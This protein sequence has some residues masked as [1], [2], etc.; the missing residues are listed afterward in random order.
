M[1]KPI[2]IVALASLTYGCGG[3]SSNSSSDSN[4]SSDNTSPGTSYGAVAPYDIAKYQDILSN[5]DFQVSDP[6]GTEGN[7]TSEVKDGDFDGYISD[8]FYADEET[9][10]LIFKM[11]NYKMRSEV[12]EGEN[13]DINETGVR[14]SLYAEISLPDIEHGMAS[15]P[16]DHDEVTVATDPQQRHR[17]EW[18]RLYPSSTIACRLG[19]RDEMASLVTTGQS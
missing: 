13:F 2:L 10:N 12:R 9:E 1:N 7:K 8:Y 15:S 17:R 19:A 14:R 11:A 5:S 4:D 16:A 6:N 3:S 18:H